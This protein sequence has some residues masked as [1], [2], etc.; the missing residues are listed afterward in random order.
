MK[1][2]VIILNY[3]VRY[4][5]ELCILS[6]Q[7]AVANL[8]AEIIVIDNNSPD[9]SCAMVRERFPD[10]ILIE[11]KENV[12]FAKANNQGVAMAKGE[13]ICILNPDTV[14]AEDTFSKIIEASEKLIH[15]G[16]LGPRLIDGTGNFLP[17]SKRNVPSPLTSFKRLFGIKLGKVK[18]YY[19][20][21]IPIH[22]IGN[23]DILVGAFIL[24][25]KENYKSVGGFDEDYFMYGEDIDLSYKM[26]KKGLENYYIGTI[27]V[28]HYKGESTDR[29]AEYIKRFYGA[30]RLFY[31]KHFKSNWLLD[32]IVSVGIRLTSLIQSFK[33]NH[34]EKRVIDQYY[35]VSGNE[36]LKRRLTDA[37]Q[38]EVQFISLESAENLGYTNN[39]L[40]FDNELLSFNEIISS[41][42]RLKKSN[43]TFK[44]RPVGCNFILGS[45]FSDG[46][47]E[48][49]TF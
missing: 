45:D 25:K 3:N 19:S 27:S 30:M 47:G 29:N 46:K 43:M 5:L 28:I 33:N 2:S 10:S 36:E 44:I 11:N 7:K 13:Y 41:M 12:G 42:Q 9:D 40:I 48:V 39:E 1:L 21:H 49:I 26:K 15:M 14:V 18:N 23:V 38:K 32:F 4:F 20:D 31:Q 35:L 22:G 24:V 6:V 17:E 16:M 37:L 8:E 34:K